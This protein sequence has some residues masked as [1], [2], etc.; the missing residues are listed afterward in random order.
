[1][2]KVKEAVSRVIK[3]DSNQIKFEKQCSFCA[4]RVIAINFKHKVRRKFAK[5]IK[6]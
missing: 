2:R 5:D 3:Y 4:I 6:I 1:M